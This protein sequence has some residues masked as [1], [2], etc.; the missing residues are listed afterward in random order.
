[1]SLT[2]PLPCLQ[3]RQ[4]QRALRVK[5]DL[6]EIVNTREYASKRYDTEVGDINVKRIIM[7][8][9][10]FWSEVVRIL[11]VSVPLVKLLRLCDNQA[12]EVI[13]KVYHLMFQAGEALK[14]MA[15]RG[16]VPWA[17]Q[18]AF[19]HERRWEYL[20]GRM[21]AAGYALDP[22]FLYHGDG[23]AL[24]H[25][26]MQGLIE[27][28]ERLSLRT[29]I[30]SAVQPDDAAR[31][32]TTESAQVQAHA[33]EC[34]R[35][36]ASFRAKENIL[37]RPMLLDCAH[38]MPPSRWWATFGYNMP[39]LQ[40]VAITVLMQPVSASACERNWSVYGQLKTPGRNRLGHDV[41]D[42]R[43]FVHESLHYRMK[44]Q[45]ASYRMQYVEWSSSDSA[46]CSDADDDEK[47]LSSLIA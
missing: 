12:K 31:E 41:A 18:A 2:Y 28:I 45:D 8:N 3:Y 32:L 42:K 14:E 34:L 10:G 22:E 17:E 21:H 19:F 46:V 29:I 27:V 13:G 7:D 44:L 47:A 6:Q 39:Q 9:A 16:T 43:V 35:Q 40:T 26:T 15:E 11:R 20:H 25:A 37:T 33:A 30:Q 36:F 1:M 4:L 23:G 38:K 5:E 24:D